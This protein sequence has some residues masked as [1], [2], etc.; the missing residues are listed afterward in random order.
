MGG[1]QDSDVAGARL[2]QHLL[3]NDVEVGRLTTATRVGS[4]TY[5][6]GSYVVDM[7]QPKRG[8]AHVMLDEG[9][10]ISDRVDSMYDISGWSLALLWGATVGEVQGAT[11]P[12]TVTPVTSADRAGGVEPGNALGYALRLTSRTRSSP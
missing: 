11:L 12:F 2:A 1:G 3:D 4:T 8:L 5:D 10:D 7:R 6:A 9:T